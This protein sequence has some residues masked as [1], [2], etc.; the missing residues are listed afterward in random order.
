MINDIKYRYPPPTRIPALA[1]LPIPFRRPPQRPR[2]ILDVHRVDAQVLVP[3]PLHLL[4]EVLVDARQTQR[5]PDKLVAVVAVH[6][7]QPH[8]HQI[9]PLDL[10]QFLFRRELPFRHFEPGFGFVGFFARDRVR[11]VDHARADFDEGGD[12]PFRGFA[13]HRDG[14]V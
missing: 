14:E 2:R 9:Q 11:L 3:Q 13:A 5:R 4:A 6:V 10:R 12:V 8:H 1:A 7:R